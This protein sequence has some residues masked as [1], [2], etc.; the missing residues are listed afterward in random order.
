M[1]Q[2]ERIADRVKRLRRAL[3]VVVCLMLVLQVGGAVAEPEP[4]AA[5]A[6]RISDEP[7]RTRFVADLTR[8]VGFKVYVLPDPYRVIVDLPEVDFR[9]PDD[10]G[11]T[12]RGLVAGYRYGS[13]E[14]GR[15][16]IVMD[17]VQPVLIERSFILHP[18]DG[19]PA[20]LIID[21]VATDAETFAGLH[22][23]E[24]LSLD[25]SGASPDEVPT[26]L[27]PISI[28]P[29][30]GMAEAPGMAMATQSG[31]DTGNETGGKES[32]DDSGAGSGRAA[33]AAAALAKLAAPGRTTGGTVSVPRPRPKP[34]SVRVAARS[35]VAPEPQARASA[36]PVI[37]I[38]PGHGG[39]D[40]GAVSR[41]G[42]AEK[43]VV[44]AFA[45]VLKETLDAAGHYE[46]HLTRSEDVFL[47][48]HERVQFARKHA[49]DLFI[50]IHADSLS[51]GTARGATVYTLADK[52]SDAEAEALAHKEN[53]S[54]IIAGV[55]LMAETEQITGI[56][57]DLAQREAKN[58]ATTF[59]KQ[60]VKELKPVAN[61]NRRPIRSAGFR[62][63]KAPDVPSVLFELGYLSNRSDETL[64]LS[65][66]WR[67][68]VA[69]AM[70]SA[71]ERYF[72]TQI[73]SGE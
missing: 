51:R 33:A 49:A 12:A 13:L 64:L 8:T 4:V 24:Q 48:L 53:R 34:G 40:P 20:R 63:L 62:V 56:L 30:P 67:S 22:R 32:S 46:V 1:G 21:L 10:S 45:N 35:D 60:L 18:R 31:N 7:E 26:E 36:R 44:Q 3:L 23:A 54:D 25:Q 69:G 27:P 6:V 55:N 39:I 61:L 11:G 15:S 16:R 52:A 68:A 50:A 14:L 70:A 17:A 2:A 57:I 9:L 71:I 5:V 42:T 59:A 72:A 29:P 65:P 66:K 43:D 28:G 58:H 37:V 41:S 73:A 19:D 47:S 38:D